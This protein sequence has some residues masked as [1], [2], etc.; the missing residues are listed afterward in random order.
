MQMPTF[1][2]RVRYFIN[3]GDKDHSAFITWNGGESDDVRMAAWFDHGQ[4]LALKKWLEDFKMIYEIPSRLT[5]EIV[6]ITEDAFPKMK[7]RG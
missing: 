5:F 3:K 7:S 1:A 2:I 4:A 6:N